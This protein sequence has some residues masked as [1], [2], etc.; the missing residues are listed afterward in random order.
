MVGSQNVVHLSSQLSKRNPG[1]IL[2]FSTIVPG[3]VFYGFVAQENGKVWGCH[4]S[5]G[6][7][8]GGSFIL[9][10]SAGIPIGISA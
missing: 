8:G 9:A 4:S 6:E 7:N 5:A 10:G 3:I 1:D 2:S